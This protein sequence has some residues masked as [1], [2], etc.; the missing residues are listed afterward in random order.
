MTDKK[1]ILNGSVVDVI[2]YLIGEY[3]KVTAIGRDDN[4]MVLEFEKE[5]IKIYVGTPGYIG[6]SSGFTDRVNTSPTDDILTIMSSFATLI[7]RGLDNALSKLN[8]VNKILQYLEYYKDGCNAEIIK[9]DNDVVIMIHDENDEYQVIKFGD[10]LAPKSY[11]Q[12]IYDP[13]S[14]VE[15]LRHYEPHEYRL[16]AR[17]LVKLNRHYGI[18]T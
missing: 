14:T 5:V 9:L 18:V 3:G 16:L 15:E 11:T 2:R 4:D 13:D 17:K 7:S 10:D 1:H 12:D 6:K 8:P